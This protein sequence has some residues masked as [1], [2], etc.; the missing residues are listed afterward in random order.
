M[1]KIIFISGVHGV[2]KT[3]LCNEIKNHIEINSYSC[4]DLIKKHSNFIE[5]SKVVDDSDKN[6][7][8]L[9]QAVDEIKDSQFILDGHFCLIGRD[10]LIIKLEQD[11]FLNMLPSMIINVSC[12]VEIIKK[13]LFNRDGCDFSKGLLE[14]LQIEE[15]GMAE[16]IS[17]VLNIPLYEYNSG[18]PIDG[19]LNALV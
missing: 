3:T 11:V 8:V 9:L 15:S 14:Q 12:P 17:T 2:G 16:Y 18:D 13:R 7:F 1:K 19:I 10:S 5:K 6:Q 4:S